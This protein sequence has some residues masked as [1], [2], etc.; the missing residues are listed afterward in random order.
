[1]N[2]ITVDTSLMLRSFVYQT[3]CAN[4]GATSS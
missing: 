2:V 4:D 1:M 3:N